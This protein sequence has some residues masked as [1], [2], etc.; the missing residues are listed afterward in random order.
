MDRVVERIPLGGLACMDAAEAVHAGLDD[1]IDFA[2]LRSWN[3][4]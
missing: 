2:A 1:A 3:G 4:P